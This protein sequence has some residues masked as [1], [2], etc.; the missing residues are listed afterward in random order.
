MKFNKKLLG[1]VFE[2]PVHDKPQTDIALQICEL[3]NPI[4]SNIWIV[5]VK[6][7]TTTLLMNPAQ[8]PFMQLIV[9]FSVL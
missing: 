9:A 6:F 4:M 7:E 3:S 2:S 1:L 8:V 5:G